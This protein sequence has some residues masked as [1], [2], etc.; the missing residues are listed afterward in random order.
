MTFI[1]DN[2]LLVGLALVSG[3]LL[4]WP[5]LKR[6]GGSATLTPLDAT[7]LINHD[8]AVI[9][10]IRAEKDFALG[11]LAGARNLPQATLAERASELVRFK[12]RPLLI[13]CDNGQQSTRAIATFK[14]VGFTDVHALG[15]GIAAWKTAA[16]PLVLATRGD[17]RSGPRDAGR[18]GKSDNRGRQQKPRIAGPEVVEASP[19]PVLS[20]TDATVVGVDDKAAEDGRMKEVS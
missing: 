15:G 5:L 8:N 10:D 6:G 3:G 14:G 19:A 20:I 12:A 2:L 17:A 7:Q 11:S 1:L 9:V 4:L 13:I 16:L 18:K